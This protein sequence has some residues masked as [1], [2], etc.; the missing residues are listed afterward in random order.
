MKFEG[1][2]QYLVYPGDENGVAVSKDIDGLK[3]MV[4]S[5]K[6]IIPL[7]FEYLPVIIEEDR[8]FQI[9]EFDI[10]KEI[11]DIDTFFVKTCA[12]SETRH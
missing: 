10:N 11:V 8:F 6:S 3:P 12:L 4:N 9:E 7:Q 5:L 2:D 1:F